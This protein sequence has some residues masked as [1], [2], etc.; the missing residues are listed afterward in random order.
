[1]KC[2]AQDCER[3][4]VA[5]GLCLMHYKRVR[6]SGTTEKRVQERRPLA[7]RFNEKYKVNDQTGC[8]EWT[9]ALTDGYGVINAGG[10][11][12]PIR[13][14]RVSF[15]L[16]VGKIPDGN[17]YHGTCVLHRCDNPKCVNPEHLFLGT[18]A[19]NVADMD[20]KGRRVS[21]PRRGPL[22][23][24][25]GMRRGSAHPAAKLDEE[26]VAEIRAS[27]MDGQSLADRYGVSKTTISRI[28]LGKKWISA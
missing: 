15:E 27:A 21:T 12:G 23:D 28:R 19:D 1:M 11:S 3:D 16:F 2:S 20:A 26:Q 8:W 25:S 17:G 13:A 10:D 6:N 22:K 5:K 24:K 9:G 18:N 4:A 7:D 14:H